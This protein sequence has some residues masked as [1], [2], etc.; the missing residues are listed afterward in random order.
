LPL[1][2]GR[3]GVVLVGLLGEVA[4]RDWEGVLRLP[5]DGRLELLEPAE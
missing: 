2:L 4:F 5:L 1:A 3:A